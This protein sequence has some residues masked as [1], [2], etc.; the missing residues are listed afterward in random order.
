MLQ[1]VEELSGRPV[2]TWKD[3][4]GLVRSDNGRPPFRNLVALNDIVAEALGCRPQ[5]RK[6][7]DAYQA[8]VSRFGTEL[9][10]LLDAPAEDIESAA[11]ARIAEGVARVRS[12][13]ILIEPGYDGEYGTV[14]VFGN[15]A[16]PAAAGR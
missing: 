9:A 5:A 3:E 15:R 2:E 13:D 6:A 1:R 7:T 12:G 10:V 14:K 8:L 4:D 16:D 11:G